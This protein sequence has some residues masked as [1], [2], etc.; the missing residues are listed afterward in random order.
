MNPI[1]ISKLRVYRIIP[2]ANLQHNLEHGLHCKNAGI[3]DPNYV[4]IG[5]GEIIDRRD[6]MI[7]KCYP[8]TFV[9]DYVPFYFSIRTPMLYNIVTGYSVNRVSQ[10][11]I[12]YLCCRVRDLATDD[13]QWCYTNGNAAQK[14]TKFFRDLKN[15]E[16]KVDW[17][18]VNTTDFRDNN[19]DGDEDRKRKKHAEFLVKD[20]VPAELITDIVVY[21]DKAKKRVEAIVQ[22]L[23]SDVRVHINPKSKFYF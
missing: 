11:E 19:A 21:N 18:S 9:N 10:E 2:I 7:V 1:D 6:G 15:I 17:H 4:G 8:D 12:I 13:F 5:N 20:Y 16:T 14:I 22:G 3:V 23:G